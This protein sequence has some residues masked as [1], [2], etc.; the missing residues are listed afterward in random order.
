MS[1]KIISEDLVAIFLRQATV[2]LNKAF[3]IGFTILERSKDFM[4]KQ[5]Y[6]VIRP[7]LK[8]ANVQVLFSDTDSYGLCVTTSKN[9]NVEVLQKL[10][11]IFDFSNYPI[12]SPRYN[13]ENAAKLGF[14]KD[15]LQ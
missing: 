14:W 3:P 7:K 2:K 10:K 11:D 15:E 12:S 1:M 6:Q 13:K 8:H 9:R 4:Y 5:L